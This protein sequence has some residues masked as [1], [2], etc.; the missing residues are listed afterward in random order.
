MVAET[1]FYVTGSIFFVISIFILF[2]TAVYLLKLLQI[3]TKTSSE[4]RDAA[5]EI[6]NKVANFYIGFAGL[7]ALLERLIEFK[8][9]HDEKKKEK[10]DENEA[11]QFAKEAEKEA[12]AEQEKYE[13]QDKDGKKNEEKKVKKIKVVEITQE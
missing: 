8:K 11:R 1:I 12:E 5:T 2:A 13:P 3:F 4:I 7:T 10:D 9:D 6:K